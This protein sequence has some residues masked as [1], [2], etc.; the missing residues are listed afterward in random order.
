MFSLSIHVREFSNKEDVFP[1]LS[2]FSNLC[3]LGIS[4]MQQKKLELISEYLSISDFAVYFSFQYFWLSID[5]SQMR[6]LQ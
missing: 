5:G 6:V 4:L 2:S 1:K 3:I